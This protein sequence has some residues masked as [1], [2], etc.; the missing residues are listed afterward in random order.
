[1]PARHGV[2]QHHQLLRKPTE[3]SEVLRQPRKTPETMLV[4]ERVFTVRDVATHLKMHV[5]A[6]RRLIYQAW[7]RAFYV[8]E[9]RLRITEPYLQV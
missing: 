2:A 6:G 1:M 5:N 9:R 4:D 8:G 7:L 3:T